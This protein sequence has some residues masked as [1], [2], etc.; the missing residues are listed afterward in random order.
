MKNKITVKSSYQDVFDYL[1]GQRPSNMKWSDFH[2]QQLNFINDLREDALLN[3]EEFDNSKYWRFRTEVSSLGFAQKHMF[4]AQILADRYSGILNCNLSNRH[5][6]EDENKY[7]DFYVHTAFTCLAE[8]IDHL[9][10]ASQNISASAIAHAGHQWRK[11]DANYDR[12]S[13]FQNKV[14]ERRIANIREMEMRL[15]GWYDE[16]YR[17]KK[18]EENMDKRSKQY[19]ELMA[20]PRSRPI[21]VFVEDLFSEG[22]FTKNT[23]WN[24]LWE[25]PEEE[26]MEQWKHKR[27]F[28][29]NDE[30]YGISRMNDYDG[31]RLKK[32]KEAV[33]LWKR[34]KPGSKERTKLWNSIRPNS[35][36]DFRDELFS[37]LNPFEAQ[38]GSDP[39]AIH[40]GS[41]DKPPQFKGSWLSIPEIRKVSGLNGHNSIMCYY[42]KSNNVNT[43]DEA[44]VR[45]C[46]RLRLKKAA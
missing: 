43:E 8:L 34:T 6:F 39:D 36:L 17:L 13:K 3:K 19:K 15:Q 32:L 12:T 9:R 26:R 44:L 40:Y 45:Q 46:K 31:T 38:Y 10:I 28:T 37:T 24:S 7:T 42:L 29:R 41:T 35:F 33:E 14:Y 23:V 5:F 4:M 1:T 18:E 21:R 2:K 25:D 20:N 16:M 11:K 27:W 30:F 22:K